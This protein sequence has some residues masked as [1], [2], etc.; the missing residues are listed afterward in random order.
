MIVS[1]VVAA[2]ENGEIGKDNALLW[3]IPSDL[4]H[5]KRLTTGHYIIMGRKTFESIGKPLPNRKH[6]I[7]SRKENHQNTENV[8]YVNSIEN[9]VQLAESAGESEAFII[10]G[11]QIYQEVLEKHLAQKIYLSRVNFDGEA[12]TF[13]LFNEKE[14]EKREQTTYEAGGENGPGYLLQVWKKPELD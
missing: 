12:D 8:T 5:F 6:I 11:G 13:F 14:F 7:V 2:G 1:I 4:R 10:G 3:Q 9:A